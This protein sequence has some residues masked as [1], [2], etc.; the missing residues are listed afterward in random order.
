MTVCG[1]ICIAAIAVM[2]ASI[3][4]HCYEYMGLAFIVFLN[5]LLVGFSGYISEMADSSDCPDG[6]FC[7]NLNLTNSHATSF[8]RV[9]YVD[10]YPMMTETRHVKW[11]KPGESFRVGHARLISSETIDADINN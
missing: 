11:L 1:W 2:V 10:R 6:K 9:E 3:V 5:L 8:L 7:Y 4:W